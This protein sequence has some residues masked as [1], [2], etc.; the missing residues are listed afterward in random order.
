MSFT[1]QHGLDIRGGRVS[2]SSEHRL[3]LRPVC[4]A[5]LH[6]PRACWAIEYVNCELNDA[7][8]WLQSCL[9]TGG[10]AQTCGGEVRV[11]RCGGR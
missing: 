7:E 8:V 11:Q 5:L 2:L 9:P 4:D 1:R 6:R 10:A 3:T